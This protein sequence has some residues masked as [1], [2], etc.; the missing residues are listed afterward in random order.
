[1]TDAVTTETE[2]TNG[3]TVADAANAVDAVANAQNAVGAESPL[4]RRLNVVLALA[5]IETEV[6]QRLRTLARTAKMAGFRPGKVPMKLI[7]QTHGAKAHQDALNDAVEKGFVAELRRQGFE[8]AGYPHFEPLADAG[9]GKIGFTAIF[10][11]YPDVVLA[12]ISAES[13]EKPMLTVTEADFDKTLEML[14]K[15]RVTYQ[16]AERAA[17]K[18]DR[19]TVDFTGRIDG[20]EF[21][22]GAATDYSV[23]VGAGSMLPEFEAQLEGG[24]VVAG[25]T[26]TFDVNLPADYQSQD[27]AGKTAQFTLTVKKVEAAVLPPVDA[28]LAKQLGVAD[29]N[30]ETML[31]E[32]R[33]NLHREVKKRLASRTKEQVMNL[34]LK[35]HPI[36]APMALVAA[37]AQQMVKETNAMAESRGM[38]SMPFRPE[39]FVDPASRRVK[40]GLIVGNLVRTKD[41]RTT[42]EQVRAVVD[43][44]AEA[45]EDAEEVVRWHYENPKR[46]AEA[47]A[48]AL[49]NNVVEWVL[50]NAAV[51]ERTVDFDELMGAQ[52]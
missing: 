17:E 30:V 51:V 13:L 41:L 39:W 40:L 18:G 52:A 31:A 35:T 4:T 6:T 47:E 12:D 50:A 43:A 25:A 33:A 19:L 2:T 22:G 28:E 24:D 42:P 11:V 21:A 10:E 32:I 27:V 23:L 46:L 45:F 37:E 48:L 38:A 15:Q 3:A 7:E 14:R 16:T 49:E 8:M 9:E 44:H 5:D 29:G 1:M 34:L 26:K 36:D 20:E